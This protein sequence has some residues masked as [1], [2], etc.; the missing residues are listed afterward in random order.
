MLKSARFWWQAKVLRNW[1]HFY[2]SRLRPER[3]TP[4]VG[5][6]SF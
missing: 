6:A 1:L 5:G 2:W 3:P 4:E